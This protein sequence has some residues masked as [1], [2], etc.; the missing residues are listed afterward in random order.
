MS[1]FF[2][3]TVTIKDSDKFHAYAGKARDTFA[4]FG[5]EL[6]LRGK[7][8]G[9]FVG[10]VS[11]QAVGIV[12]FPDLQTLENWFQSDAYQAI[13]PLRDAAADMVIAKYEQP[14]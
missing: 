10:D 6:V 13:I 8:E 3:A 4:A 12:K 11:H 1:A 7:F 14:D 2:V 9:T 5:G